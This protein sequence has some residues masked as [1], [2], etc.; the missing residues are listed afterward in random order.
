MTEFFT[1]LF[2]ADFMAHALCLRTP[3][4]IRLHAISDAVV[5]FSYFVI[6]LALLQ[7]VRRRKDL[8]FNGIFFLF[9]VFIMSCGTTHVLSIV[10]LWHPIYRFEG[11][12]KAV[13]AIT[14]F[15]TAIV[16]VRLVPKVASI[17]GIAEWKSANEALQLEVDARLAA[18]REVRTLNVDLEARVV[19][20][21]RELTRKNKSLEDL[22]TALDLT[23]ACIRD[24][25]GAI[26]FWSRGSENQYGWTK[27]EAVGQLSHDLLRTE[28]PAPRIEIDAAL[29]SAGSWSGELTHTAKNGS[30]IHVA[31]HWVLRHNAENKISSVV[32]VST[33]IIDRIRADQALKRMA[34]IVH[35]SN[36]AIIS[37]TLEGSVTSWNQAAER[38]FGYSESEMIGES[39]LKIIPPRNEEGNRTIID[40]I[41]LGESV[42]NYE[43]LRYTKFGRDICVS[44]TVSPI[45][46]SKGIVVGASKIARDIT[47]RKAFE[48][49]LRLSEERQRL[50]AEAA[51][52][53][54]WSWDV[55]SGEIVW[56]DRC[57]LLFGFRSSDPDPNL[58]TALARIHPDD[59]E[60][61]RTALQRTAVEG[62]DFCEEYRIRLHDS[63]TKWI[64]AKGRARKNETGQV[65]HVH[66]TAIDLTAQKYAEE[67]LRRTNQ[68]LGQFAYAAAHDLQEPLRNISLS[69]Q[70][71]Q[72]RLPEVRSEEVT[73]LLNCAIEGSQRMHGMV[74]DL[75]AYSRAIDREKVPVATG[76]SD[77]V[78]QA[79]VANL[80][81]QIDACHALVTWDK[82]LPVVQVQHLDLVQIFQ[83]L[84]SNSLKYR[85]K[86]SPVIHIS[87]KSRKGECVFAVRDNGM[88]IPPQFH[89]RIFGVFK[90][91]HSRDIPGNGIGL[92]LC[93]RIVEHY[94][95]KIWVE[96]S[97]NEGA[98]FYFTAVQS[99]RQ[100]ERQTA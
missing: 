18:E 11:L 35:S 77:E 100:Y 58:E 75:L 50:S 32:E 42:Q 61:L 19:E 4:L 93:K 57:K 30:E 49:A 82:Y 86:E 52:I 37:Q 22:T 41:R 6:P 2:S 29:Q 51:N 53:G 76:S 7:L 12:A 84:I 23:N 34:A 47:E 40:R 83:N 81:V 14:S 89:E 9:A 28:F 59:E 56:S 95:G 78:L 54:T 60:D 99:D 79:V 39:I 43:T 21:T 8:V 87:S 73:N 70:L 68:E 94:G 31:S 72:T 3:D 62:S 69:L 5:A 66:G 45:F 96:S 55:K 20:R 98:T 44:L 63:T 26:T 36:D 74:K 97:L 80:K 16:L 71:A 85:G 1:K 10:T 64:G 88:G 27:K 91:L 33:D 15:C 65:S 92:A 25:N 17:P 38:M 48:A 90:R 46:D 13:T 67:A 24:L